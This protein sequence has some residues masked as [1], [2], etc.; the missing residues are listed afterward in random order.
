MHFRT[1]NAVVWP[2]VA[3]MVAMAGCGSNDNPV[4][5]SGDTVA[6]T[7]LSTNPV[8]GATGVAI[9]TASFSEAMNAS[10]VTPATFMLTGPGPTAVSGTVAYNAT[11]HIATFTPTTALAPSTAYT[12]TIT[13]GAKDASG[14]ALASNRSW[15]F[16]MAATAGNQAS[17]ALGGAGAFAILAGSTVTS[18]GA[19][20]LTGDQGVS[21]G[22]RG[23]RLPTGNPDRHG[24]RGRRHFSRGD[25]RSDHGV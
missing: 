12:A 10:T 14:N 9:I 17:V 18:T 21:P 11:T 13:T 6:P 5:P 4:S 20:D 25:G 3:L 15:S 16:S 2:L 24:P 1:S 23:D 19:T 22:N 7:V 8:N